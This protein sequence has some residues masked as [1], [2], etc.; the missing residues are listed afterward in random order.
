MNYAIVTQKQ[1]PK[2]LRISNK[3]NEN[4]KR[5]NPKNT[6]SSLVVVGSIISPMLGF[7]LTNNKTAN[8]EL[9]YLIGMS[10]FFIFLLTGSL[11]KHQVINDESCLSIISIMS[12]HLYFL[13]SSQILQTSWIFKIS[14]SLVI[15]MLTIAINTSE[16]NN[17]I[18]NKVFAIFSVFFAILNILFPFN[19]WFLVALPVCLI[20]L[21]LIFLSE[22]RSQP[23]IKKINKL[24]LFILCPITCF[25]LSKDIILAVFNINI[26]F[27]I[28]LLML[29]FGFYAI[30]NKK[31]LISNEIIYWNSFFIMTISG[32]FYWTDYFDLL[33]N[34]EIAFFIGLIT[35]LIYFIGKMNIY[36]KQHNYYL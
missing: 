14:I 17:N 35:Y 23:N 26:L 9:F 15:F 34:S 7:I 5:D 30:W 32:L 29:F 1:N 11:F 2:N 20:Y 4:I 25:V 22:H 3:N 16:K 24:D 33:L 21:F 18:I 19:F 10:M 8:D 6:V 13:Y 36:I 28:S 27:F 31:I 12:I